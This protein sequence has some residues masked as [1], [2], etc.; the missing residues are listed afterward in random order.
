VASFDQRERQH[1]EHRLVRRVERL[2]YS[3]SLQQ[4]APAPGTAA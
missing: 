2:G 1:V 4:I 3:L